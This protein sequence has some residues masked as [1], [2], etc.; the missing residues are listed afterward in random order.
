LQFNSLIL[1]ISILI[2]LS[3]VNNLWKC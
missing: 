3:S 1:L 2:G